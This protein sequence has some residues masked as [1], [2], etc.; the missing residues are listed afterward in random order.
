MYQWSLAWLGKRSDSSAYSQLEKQVGCIEM[1]WSSL[2]MKDS[3]LC[4]TYFDIPNIL[5]II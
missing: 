5:D 2:Y 4:L 3:M 1:L